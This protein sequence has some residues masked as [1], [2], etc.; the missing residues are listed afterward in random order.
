MCSTRL[1]SGS[2]A[3]ASSSSTPCEFLAL[4]LGCREF[5]SDSP[6][7]GSLFLLDGATSNDKTT[8]YTNDPH[9]FVARGGMHGFG[10]PPKVGRVAARVVGAACGYPQ[11]TRQRYRRLKSRGCP[12]VPDLAVPKT[13][14]H[15]SACSRPMG[16]LPPNQPM[17]TALAYAQRTPASVHRASVCLHVPAALPRICMGLI[18][19]LARCA[20]AVGARPGTTVRNDDKGTGLGP[21]GATLGRSEQGP[22]DGVADR[23]VGDD[24][25]K[26]GG[27]HVEW[28]D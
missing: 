18:K 5:T 9:G 10:I 22:L 11:R 2:G 23:R 4:T 28:G 20:R 8:T 21:H 15:L 19:A 13:T 17:P 26:T 12:R 24:G 7:S 16:P 25:S 1:S 3:R 6:D 14:M 27:R